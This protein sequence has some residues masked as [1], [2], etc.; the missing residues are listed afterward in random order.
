[1]AA[2][3][4]ANHRL[5]V[6]SLVALAVALVA[7]AQ[8]ALP[9]LASSTPLPSRVQLNL[10]NSNWDAVKVEVRIGTAESCDL[11]ADAW[12]RTLRRGQTWGVVTDLAVCWRRE[13]TPGATTATWGT[14]QRPA[15]V[16]GAV[17]EVDL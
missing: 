9:A 17:A 3:S 12:V 13:A 11:N 14:W 16:A 4:I 5:V 8:P 15:L 10:R 1:M 6:P 7:A 2:R